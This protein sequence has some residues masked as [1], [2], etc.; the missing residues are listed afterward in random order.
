MSV[1]QLTGSM[2]VSSTNA[3]LALTI[4][5][6]YPTSPV[7]TANYATVTL[8]NSTADTVTQ[9]AF[10][11]TAIANNIAVPLVTSAAVALDPGDSTTVTLTL[12]SGL[13]ASPTV[14][15][16]FAAPPTSG[17][18][19]VVV[20]LSDLTNG[21]PTWY[22]DQITVGTTAA[23]LPAQAGTDW[24]LTNDATNPAGTTIWIGDST[25]QHTPIPRGSALAVSIP[26]L[27]VVYAR[28]SQAGLLLDILGGA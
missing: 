6:A 16:T 8:T 1:I 9:I 18:L 4:P 23:A 25:G 2:P 20:A 22:D 24:L 27:S 12:A 26:Q 13:A 7:P 11:T 14:I 5:L 10:R 19:A 21:E 15:V 17:T 3:Q 28:G